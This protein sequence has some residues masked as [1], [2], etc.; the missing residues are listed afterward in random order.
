MSDYLNVYERRLNRLG[1]DYQ[2]RVQG[3]RENNFD[4]YLAKSLNRVFCKYINNADDV[5]Y[6]IFETNRQDSSRTQCYLLTEVSRQIP[7]GTILSVE[8]DIH[9]TSHGHDENINYQ[10]LWMVWWLEDDAVKGYNKYVILKMNQELQWS[11]DNKIYTQWGYFSGPGSQAI[12]GTSK[13]ANNA[14]PYS[15]RTSLYMFVMPY[16]PNLKKDNYFEITYNSHTLAFV[17]T[18]IDFIT[19]EGVM[20]VSADPSYT[21]DTTVAPSY[22]DGPSKEDQENYFWLNGG[23]L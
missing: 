9:P 14:A 23:K 8:N 2:S 20:Y 10:A 18:D 6:G 13:N 22:P 11:I 21:R 16:H 12:I 4:N 15:E 5:F 17:I 3:Q 19:T 1:N 7:N